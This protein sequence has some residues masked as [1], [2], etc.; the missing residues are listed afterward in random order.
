LHETRRWIADRPNMRY[1]TRVGQAVSRVELSRV[2]TVAG[3][4][5]KLLETGL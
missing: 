3:M 5:T 4:R 2:R 1:E